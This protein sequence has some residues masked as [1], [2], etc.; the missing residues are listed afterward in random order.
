MYDDREAEILRNNHQLFMRRA[1]DQN[2]GSQADRI[3]AA[4]D[5]NNA[6]D[7]YF[8]I[9]GKPLECLT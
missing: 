3:R 8:E 6:A 7:R 5:A 9:T 1:C 2:Y 4:C